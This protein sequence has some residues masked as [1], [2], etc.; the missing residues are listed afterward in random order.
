M[1]CVGQAAPHSASSRAQL[2]QALAGAAADEDSRH[3]GAFDFDMCRCAARGWCSGGSASILL[4][5]S[6]CGTAA[7]ADFMQ[8]ALHF[9]DLLRMVRVG[10]VHHVQQQVGIGRLLQRGLESV[11]Q[12]VRQVA[13]EADRVGQA[14]PSAASASARY[15]WRVVVSSV[16]NSWSA[17]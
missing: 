6:T 16:A 17:A 10:G 11:D 4:K 5:T 15:S 9:L 3:L 12:A 13:D 1:G 7:G 14:P 8:H 2:G